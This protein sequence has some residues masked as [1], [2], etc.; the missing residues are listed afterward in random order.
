MSKGGGSKTVTSSSRVLPEYERFANETLSLAGQM[1]QQGYVPYEGQRLANFNPDE[2]AAFDRIR[3]LGSSNLGL[4]Y[5]VAQSVA[6][7]AAPTLS[8]SNV[9]AGARQFMNPY[10]QQVVDTTMQELQRQ[11]AAA[12]NQVGA[13]AASAG[14]FGGSRHGI[15]EGETNRAFADVAA[16]TA[17]SL[18]QSGYNNALANAMQI[19]R[20]N[21]QAADANLNRRLAAA[22][23]MG[24]LGQREFDRDLSYA[25]ALSGSGAVQRDRDQALLDLRLADFYDQLQTPL[26]NLALRQ[27]ALGMTPLGSVQKIPVQRSGLN[28][29]SLLSGLGGL[30][31]GFGGTGGLLAALK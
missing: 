26:Q 5:N 24:S 7:A 19:E 12:L 22:A 20:S 21:Q 2:Q 28:F 8:G 6:G 3:G 29:G 27:S 25:N 13:R 23:Q 15:S 11:N 17:A 30:A 10:Q 4:G 14:A 16:R 9:T 18:N 31:T 1:A